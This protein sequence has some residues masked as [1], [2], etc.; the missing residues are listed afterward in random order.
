MRLTYRLRLLYPLK[1]GL[2]FLAAALCALPGQPSAAPAEL[3]GYTV[4]IK[5]T[6]ISGLSSGAFM[7]V[8]FQVSHSSIIKGAGIIAGGPYFCAQGDPSTLN[9]ISRATKAC[10]CT[11]QDITTPASCPGVSATCPALSGGPGVQP[12]INATNGNA[13]Q[14][15]IDPTSHLANHKVFLFSGKN[16]CVVSQH[17]MND[18]KKYYENYMADGNIIYVNT[19]AAD[20][21]MPTDLPAHQACTAFGSPFIS[22]CGFDGAK[23]LLEQIYGPLNPRNTGTLSGELIEFRQSDFISGAN[24]HGMD[25]SGWLYVPAKCKNGEACKLH[26]ALHGCR[27][28]HSAIGKIFMEKAGYNEW[29]DTNNIIVLYP[30]AVPVQFHLADLS[31]INPKGCWN[32]WGYASD[33]DYANKNG[34][35]I[36]AIRAMADRI[37]G[38]APSPQPAAQC[39][40]ATNSG[41]VAAGRAYIQYFFMT[42]AKGS[43]EYL[44]FTFGGATT[45]K[46][47]GPNFYVIGSCP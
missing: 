2:F 19:I 18:L 1:S 15:K 32:W 26:I 7:A 29:A 13:S 31:G 36:A 27:Q 46:Q 23:A 28:G 33:L 6:S 9:R 21:S 43:N 3:R 4:D 10:S 12:S 34:R 24:S 11:D 45:L 25:E 42:R 37:A 39:F 8:Q 38:S 17:V 22:N 16:D 14:N 30:Q 44:G 41:H 35:Q 20:H 40:T 47:T 5:Q